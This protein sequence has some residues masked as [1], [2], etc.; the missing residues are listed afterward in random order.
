VAETDGDRLLC[1]RALRLETAAQ[2]NGA[3]DWAKTALIAAI[4]DLTDAVRGVEEA[5]RAMDNTMDMPDYPL[6]G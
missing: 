5:V 2:D 1:E 3:S 4:L 6:Y